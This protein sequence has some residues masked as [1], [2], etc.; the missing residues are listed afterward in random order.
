M[1]AEPHAQLIYHMTEG[2]QAK[3]KSSLMEVN[4]KMLDMGEVFEPLYPELAPGKHFMDRFSEQVTFFEKPRGMKPEDWTDTLDKAVNRACQLTDHVS[5]FLDASST[6]KDCLQ[7]AF[8]AFIEHRGL[9]LVQIKCP[10]S[11]ATAPDAE[12]F[13]IRL[14]LLRCLQLE[15]IETI[16]VFTDSVASTH[17]VVDPSTHS[18]QSHSL[19]VIQALIPWLE[20]DPLR[21]VQFWYVPS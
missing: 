10:A 17:T 18:G 6:K 11:R 14:G 19:A 20:V 5:V 4:S 3:V 7:A 13:A 8:M 1:A 12:L 2:M 15:D 9:D 21:K 16:L